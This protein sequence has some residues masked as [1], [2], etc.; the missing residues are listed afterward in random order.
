MTTL[1]PLKDSI[2]FIWLDAD[3]FE[4]TTSSGIV[5]QRTLNTARNRWGKIIAVGPLS[6][7]KVGEYILC[8]NHVEAYGAKHP[9]SPQNERNEKRDVWRVRDENVICVTSDYN[10]T[11]PLNDSRKHTR[12][13]DWE[14]MNG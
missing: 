7:A 1:K 8:D 6:T 5:L 11:L 14:T 10:V 2:L 9:D 13:D 3:E 12:V 4:T